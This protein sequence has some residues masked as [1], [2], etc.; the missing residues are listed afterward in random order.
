MLPDR[1]E[2]GEI[3]ALIAPADPPKFKRNHPFIRPLIPDARE[4]EAAYF[5]RTGVFPI[6]H[7][8]VVRNDVY[9][10]HPW[11][12][13]SLL[14][15]FADAKKAVYSDL[16]ETLEGLRYTLPWLDGHVDKVRDVMGEDFWPYGVSRNR[17]T[18]ETYLRYLKHQGLIQRT[19]AVEEL[20]APTRWRRERDMTRSITQSI[21]IAAPLGA[22]WSFVATRATCTSGPSASRP[23]SR[24]R[25]ATRTAS[26]RPAASSS[27]T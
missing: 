25:S 27:C 4:A 9:E 11:V 10:K 5:K 17:A 8:L 24:R 23:R 26:R 21:G 14:R 22:V 7:L 3:D 1:L 15:A 20:F 18:L 19:P 2:A 12:A 16:G 13:S 6:L